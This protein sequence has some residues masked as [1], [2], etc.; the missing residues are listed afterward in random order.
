MQILW[1]CQE[2]LGINETC[3]LIQNCIKEEED[4]KKRYRGIYPLQIGFKACPQEPT[5]H[6]PAEGL[7]VEVVA[8]LPWPTKGCHHEV[9][10]GPLEKS[11]Q[12]GG[13]AF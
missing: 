7:V 1:M 3:A 9:V 5:R 10:R 4:F 8:I 2:L 12:L 11:F 6:L 13:E